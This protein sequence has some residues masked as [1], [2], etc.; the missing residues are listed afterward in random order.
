MKLSL[1]FA[2]AAMVFISSCN[3]PPKIL[4]GVF[5]SDKPNEGP[6]PQALVLWD[7]SRKVQISKP[8]T[9]SNVG[10]T[11]EILNVSSFCTYV[12]E[13]PIVANLEIQFAFGRGPAAT[14]MEMDYPYFIAVTRKDKAVI[15]KETFPLR[16]KF[17]SEDEIVY[18]TEK[19]KSITIPRKQQNTSGIN[20]EILV[21]FELTEA[22][23]EFAR[24]GKRF[25][26][27]AGSHQQ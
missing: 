15:S 3:N 12:D 13:D 7:V 26:V 5:A 23:L 9:F 8:E 1:L 14:G 10:F 16:V 6:C 21:G 17:R 22:E 19:F 20:F 11:G 27:P 2:A 24:S 18:V 4:S 25:R